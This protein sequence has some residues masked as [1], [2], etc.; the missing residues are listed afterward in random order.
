MRNVAASADFTPEKAARKPDADCILLIN[1][2]TG[3]L[4]KVIPE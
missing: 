3:E 1:A 4:E 2:T